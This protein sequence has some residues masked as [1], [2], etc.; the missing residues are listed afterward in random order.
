MKNIK[1]EKRSTP[2]SDPILVK[3]YRS[4]QKDD[5]SKRF[6]AFL[7]DTCVILAPIAL[8]NIMVLAV[9]GN[10]V[11]AH[12][13][14]F[15]SKTILIML[16]I[17]ILFF[18]TFVYAKTKGQS[19]GMKLF[20]LRVIGVSGKVAAP[21]KL[22]FREWI[23]FDIPFIVLMYFTSIFGPILYWGAN[24]LL[25]FFDPKHRSWI[26]FVVRTKVVVADATP[27]VEQPKLA[28]EVVKPMPQAPMEQPK[29]VQEPVRLQPS[30]DLH[31]HSNF[32]ANGQYNV[33]EIF[34]KAKEKGLK[35]ISITDL[36]SAKSIPIA[37]RMS[38]LYHIHY[39]PGIE[40]SCELDDRRVRVLGYFVDFPHELFNQIEN[41]SLLHEKQAS[42]ERVRKFENIIGMKVPV[43]RLLENNRFQ[44]I[45]GEMIAEYVLSNP[46]Y[47]QSPLLQPYLTGS[48]SI[49]PYREMAKD[50]FAYGK[51][52]YV[53]VRYP[54][55]RDVLDVIH[56]TNGVAVLAHP[57]KLLANSPDKLNQILNLNIDGIEV[58]HPDHTKED[59]AML[60]KTALDRKL[61]VSAGSDFYSTKKQDVLGNTSCPSDAEKIVEL[62]I[63]ARG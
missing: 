15:I 10:I 8:W 49:D 26:D 12:G 41:D 61:F 20:G 23:G 1:T 22:I 2:K 4:M 39:V 7:I 19:L 40:V 51:L 63:N 57:G 55:I 14:T 48:K 33:E 5:M 36:D 59:T 42:I 44:R 24:A 43:E 50:L 9:F 32:S 16:G 11:S 45:P 56:L 38:E 28:Q 47:R 46:E 29:P 60:L 31:I 27:R 34:Q 58:F 37:K 3:G 13:F 52:C 25:V 18:N 62:F 54:D 35:T 30:I 6:F 53:P 21:G 17:S